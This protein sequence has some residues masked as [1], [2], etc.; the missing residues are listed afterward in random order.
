MSAARKTVIVT[1][2]S[3]GIGAALVAA[4]AERNYGVVANSRTIKPTGSTNV[5]AVAGDA[6]DP[7]TAE[8]VVTAAL[9]HFGRL[10][11]LIN[12]AGIFIPKAFVDYTAD[13]FAAVLSVNLAGFFH[14]SQKAAARMLEQGSGHIVNITATLADQPV[15]IAPAALAV[16]TKGG[17]NAVTRA[18]AIEYADRG[19]RVNAVAPGVIKT[20]MHAPETHAFLAGLHP[21]NRMGE[22]REVVDAVLYL[23]T[24]S[25]V[26]G[27]ILHVDG[28]AHAGRW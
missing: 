22:V 5:V 21:M 9:D 26:T 8:R 25:F 12:N 20:P 14:I 10:D 15:K 17:L 24:A 2:A 16:L 27:E 28:G 13:D 3:Q 23:E 6:A 19:V 18:L 4:F 1:G 7:R 11:T